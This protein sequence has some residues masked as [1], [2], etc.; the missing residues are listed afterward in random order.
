[1]QILTVKALALKS[2][3]RAGLPIEIIL[4]I[5]DLAEFIN[6]WHD[7]SIY[8]VAHDANT[9]YTMSWFLS[10]PHSYT[11]LRDAHSIGF[12]CMRLDA[13]QSEPRDRSPEHPRSQQ[14]RCSMRFNEPGCPHRVPV[15]LAAAL[16][17]GTRAP[18]LVLVI[19]SCFL[20]S[21]PYIAY[22]YIVPCNPR[23]YTTRIRY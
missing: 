2:V 1:M 20:L 15:I 16:C 12:V 11:R 17:L 9:S 13:G 22:V 21:G 10:I 3:S 8:T 18:A 5:C 19:P 14:S 4:H 6:P 7:K 23:G